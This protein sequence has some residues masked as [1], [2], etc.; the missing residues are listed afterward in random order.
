MLNVTSAA[1][2]TAGSL[3]LLQAVYGKGLHAA[4]NTDSSRARKSSSAIQSVTPSS[5]LEVGEDG[6]TSAAM[7]FKSSEDCRSKVGVLARDS[8]I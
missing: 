4:S 3:P 2:S 5:L 7:D 8:I 1:F 6:I